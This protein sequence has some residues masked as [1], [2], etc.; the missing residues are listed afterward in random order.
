MISKPKPAAVM[1]SECHVGHIITNIITSN[2]TPLP[3]G[4]K[5]IDTTRL[6]SSYDAEKPGGRS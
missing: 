2:R 5:E 4:V 3:F 1:T 6:A